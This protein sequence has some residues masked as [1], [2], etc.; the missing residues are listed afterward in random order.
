MPRLGTGRWVVAPIECRGY[1]SVCI[2][3]KISTYAGNGYSALGVFVLYALI[4]GLTIVNV[5][6]LVY[7]GEEKDK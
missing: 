5:L 1:S 7:Q 4:C 3:E 6:Y 2:D